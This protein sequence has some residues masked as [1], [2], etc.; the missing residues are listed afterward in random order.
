MADIKRSWR[1]LN[2]RCGE[3]FDA[4]EQN[5]E[6]PSCHCVRVEWVPGGGHIAGTA[7]ACDAELRALADA[8]R[9][10]DMASAR[11]GEA[12]KRPMAQQPVARDAP[13]M[14]FGGGF[15]AQ[16]DPNRGAQCVPTANRMD[17]KTKVGIGNKLAP[18]KV[19]PGVG[20]NTTIEAQ[21]RPRP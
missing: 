11:R 5:P 15:V 7:K 6:C 12:A 9:L 1:C 21:H 19:F 16:V 18:S 20:T 3:A 4:W 13:A 17:F 2:S 8:F 14:S 10:P